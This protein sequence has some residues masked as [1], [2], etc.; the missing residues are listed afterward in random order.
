MD[1]SP[2]RREHVLLT[3]L[4]TLVSPVMIVGPASADSLSKFEPLEALKDKDYG[5]PRN[6]WVHA[7][8]TTMKQITKT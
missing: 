4:A 3:G 5:K 6:R 1:V 8:N 7:Q 2:S